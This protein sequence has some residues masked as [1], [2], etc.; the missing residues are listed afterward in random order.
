LLPTILADVTR[1]ERVESAHHGVVVV[2][3][4]DGEVV[5]SAGSPEHFAYFRSSAKPFQAVPL[6]ESGAADAFGFTPAELAFCCASHNAEAQQ[7]AAVAAML[8]K[9]GLT[10]EALQCGVKLPE[11]KQEAARVTLGLVPRSSLQHYC[12]GKHAGMLATCVHLGYPIATYM[13]PEHPL[14]R[15]I[16]AIIAEV[17]R[18]EEREIVLATDGCS[19]PT[20]G[21]PMRTFAAAFATFAA[22]ERVPTGN[23]LRHAAALN[24][25]RETMTAFPENVAGPGELD[26]DLMVISDGRFVAKLGAEGLLCVGIRD[27]GLGIVIRVLDGSG[28]GLDAVVASTLEQLELMEPP[29]LAKL[30]KRPDL[31]V[32]TA[33]G[34]QVGE[35]RPAFQLKVATP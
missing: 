17:L 23:G 11:D 32:K 10:K 13:E 5:A 27:H 22:P 26:T 9:I 35:V 31:L 4:T 34:V 3:N 18:L 1:D 33:N 29:E 30:R 20:F 7:Q 6:I 15:Q 25:L 8:A 12:S 2:A 14:Q 24:R 21:A 28:R 19:L 16:R